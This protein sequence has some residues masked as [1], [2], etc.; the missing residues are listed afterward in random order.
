ML[1]PKKMSKSRNMPGN[2]ESSKRGAV[3]NFQ[4]TPNIPKSPLVC[5][6][7]GDPGHFVKDCPHPYRPVLDPKFSPNATKTFTKPTVHFAD[8][9]L[10]GES[11][12]VNDSII[13]ESTEGIPGKPVEEACDQNE[14]EMYKLWE[15]FY[16]GNQNHNIHM[17]TE[18]VAYKT[19][20]TEEINGHGLGRE[21][22]LILIDCGASRSVC[23]RR[24]AEWWFGSTKLKL[25]LSQK[26]FRFGAGPALKSMGTTTIFIHVEPSTTNK[27]FPVIVPVKVDVVDSNVPM[28]ISHESLVRMK[29]SIDF[30]SCTLMIPSVAEIKLTNTSSGHLMIQGTRPSQQVQRLMQ[31]ENHPIYVME[32]KLPAR[33]LSEGEIKKIHVQLG[34]CSENTLET[35]IRVAQMH[36]DSS[37]IQKVLDKCGCQTAVQRITPPQVA[38]WLGKYNGEIIALDIIYP[39]KDCFNEKIAKEYPALFMIDSLSR[40]INCTLLINRASIHATQIFLNDW[41][42]TIGKPRRIITDQGGP[43]L[44]GDAWAELSDVYGRQMIHAPKYAPYQNGIAERSTRSL[45]IAVENI[46]TATNALA[47][48][49][50]ILTQA[51]I[52]KNHVPHAVTGI[53]PALA[54]TG[55]CD[56]LSGCGQTAFAHDPDKVDSLSRINN[57]LVTI[58]NA[59]NAIITADANHAIKTMLGRKAPDRFNIYFYPGASVQIAMNQSWVGTYRVVAV[60]DSNLVLGR[61]TRL[62]KWPKC[63]TRMI[64]DAETERFDATIIPP[65][66]E[67]VNK[68]PKTDDSNTGADPSVGSSNDQD[69]LV[70][71]GHAELETLDSQKDIKYSANQV[72]HTENDWCYSLLAPRDTYYH[73]APVTS[74]DIRGIISCPDHSNLMIHEKEWTNFVC[75]PANGLLPIPNHFI[76]DAT[77]FNV[78][79][80]KVEKASDSKISWYDDDI[81]DSFDPS[82]LPPR[83]VMKL[84]GARIAVE[85]EINDLLA[86]HGV[87]PP[88][89]VEVHLRDSRFK[90]IPRIRA[91]LVAKRKS[92][93]IYKG[94]LCARGDSVPLTHTPFTSSPTVSRCGSKLVVMIAAML[95]FDIHSV[96]VSQAFLQSDNLAESDRC[97]II[98]PSMIPMPWQ[99]KLHNPDVNIKMLP[100]PTHGFL[101]LRP[102]YGT[103]DA[104]LR[105]FIKLAKCLTHMGLRQMKADICTYSK[106]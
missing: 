48:S 56:F 74:V 35:T 18:I 103:R 71:G 36:V 68:I 40:F 91:T 94:R 61:A 25:D 46:I 22:P 62:F 106:N 105:W 9:S 42:G 12:A 83:V 33:V 57:S 92:V 100:S 15:N 66:N 67:N 20:A 77:D 38:C 95:N 50:E 26:Q 75:F 8:G 80:N 52:A 104:P 30:A 37:L 10:E 31:R 7:C 82:R 93:G 101:I 43:T 65:S 44:A 69:A 39:F 72:L 19:D 53:P 96:D 11:P 3:N 41:V 4:G 90:N 45:K 16:K 5:I 89:M 76:T 55:R 78:F 27:D 79:A 64:H 21:S 34:H 13:P 60:M 1:K 98:P 97:I 17:M 24:W 99:G 81:V 47:P 87:E 58:L 54:M 2:A 84:P 51:V 32:L 102:L 63:K 86:P 6:R 59:R 29:G 28:L 49:Q 23:G 88:A 14:Q 85:K 73:L 70:D